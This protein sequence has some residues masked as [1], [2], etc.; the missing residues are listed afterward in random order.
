M[1]SI[2]RDGDE[3]KAEYVL[4]QLLASIRS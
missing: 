2:D 4:Q 1:S 3:V